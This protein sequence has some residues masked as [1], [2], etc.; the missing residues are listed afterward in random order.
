VSGASARVYLAP[1]ARSLIARSH[2]CLISAL[3]G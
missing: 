2:V 3:P 1:S